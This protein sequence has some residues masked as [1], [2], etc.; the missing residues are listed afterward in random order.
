MVG[1]GKRVLVVDDEADMR[2][3]VGLVLD[4]IGYVVVEAC[5]GLEATQEVRRRHF[6][7]IVTDLNMPNLDGVQ[8]MMHVHERFPDMP[9]ILLTGEPIECLDHR[10]RAQFIECLQKPFDIGHLLDVVHLASHVRPYVMS[11]NDL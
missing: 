1:Y 2:A 7:V 4:K 11:G 10:T 5:D 6:D 9:G 3:L 8:L